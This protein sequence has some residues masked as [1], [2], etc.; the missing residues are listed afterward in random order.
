M[1]HVV[2]VAKLGGGWVST[3]DFKGKEESEHVCVYMCICVCV[4]VCVCLCVSVC[5]HAF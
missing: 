2:R 4:C 5:M 1:E 3:R